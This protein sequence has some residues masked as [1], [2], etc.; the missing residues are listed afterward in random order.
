MTSVHD[1]LVEECRSVMLH[2]NMDISR[3]MVHT[4]QVEESRVKRK[5]RE[6]KREKPYNE[7]N[8]REIW[9]FKTSLDSSRGSPTK[10]L[11]ISPR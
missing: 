6:F 9:Q 5:N 7:G 11:T 4:Q 8:I 2:D 10:F 3:L 1:D